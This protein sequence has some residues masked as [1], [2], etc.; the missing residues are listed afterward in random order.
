MKSKDVLCLVVIVAIVV[1]VLVSCRKTQ[2]HYGGPIKNVKRIPM[3][4]C[5]TLCDMHSKHCN[6]TRSHIFGITDTCE[7]RRQ[8]CF[9]ECTY[10]ISQ[11]I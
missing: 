6:L 2:E 9:A 5:F 8:S 1:F 7:R 11:R 3:T 10:S 4:D